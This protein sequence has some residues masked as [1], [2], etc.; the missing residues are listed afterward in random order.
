MPITTRHKDIFI[1]FSL[2]EIPDFIKLA[3][4]DEI[5][6]IIHTEIKNNKIEG[7]FASKLLGVEPLDIAWKQLNHNGI[8]IT[9][10][11]KWEQSQNDNFEDELMHDNDEWL[12]EQGNE[13]FH[14]DGSFNEMHHHQ[15]NNDTHNNKMDIAISKVR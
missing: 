12:M 4:S 9:K 8:P 7:M 14:E 13:D 5:Q 3:N 15:N 11:I 6:S 10:I 1:E 2:A